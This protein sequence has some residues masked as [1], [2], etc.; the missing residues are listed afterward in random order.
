MEKPTLQYDFLKGHPNDDELPAD[1]LYNLL[2]SVD[3][4]SLRSALQYGQGQGNP[5]LITELESFIE[6]QCAMDV[7]YDTCRCKTSIF[8]TEGVSHGVDLLTSAATQPGDYVLT[9]HPTYFLIAGIF[10]SHQ[11]N[12][13]TMPMRTEDGGIDFETL[14]KGF[15]TG[16]IIIP[17]LIY[18][19]PS[20]HNP[21][22][23][24][25]SNADR[26]KIT[27]L[28]HQ[29]NILVIADEVYHLLD[30]GSQ[31]RNARMVTWN[32]A[33]NGGPV[34]PNSNGRVDYA[35]VT[36]DQQQLYGCVSVSSFTKIF[37]P[38]VRCGWI[39][40]DHTVVEAVDNIGYIQSQGA[41]APVMGTILS[42]GL[43]SRTVDR[44]LQHL[45]DQYQTRCN[46]LCDILERESSI[47]LTYR[48]TGGYF[49]WVQLPEVMHQQAVK[50]FIEYCMDY[51]L[52]FMPGT[53]CNACP[54]INSAQQ[55]VRQADESCLHSY[56][57]LCFAKL[58][59]SA[60]EKGAELFL[61]CLRSFMIDEF[62]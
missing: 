58:H 57:R 18:I 12:I 16:L 60:I 45:R 32:S 27:M 24:C 10:R 4:E 51:G 41:V 22:G 15:Q 44:I 34:C 11:L 28:A 38:G 14:E 20:H 33:V 35:R 37:G 31:P 5:Q 55:H 48:P 17:R 46:L 49:V 7:G 3:S 52:R 56:A 1:D 19:I 6:R 26:E 62:G 47:N 25:M 50:K 43:S 30:W 29:Y 8:I 39:E 13:G 42:M 36:A 21:T 40:A 23:R 54:V 2:Q 9:E 53:R 59:S 61:Q